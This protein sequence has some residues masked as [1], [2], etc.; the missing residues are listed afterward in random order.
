MWITRQRLRGRRRNDGIFWKLVPFRFLLPRAATGA[1]TGVRSPLTIMLLPLILL[2]VMTP[3]R[4]SGQPTPTLV[5]DGTTAITV[6]WATE[7]PPAACLEYVANASVTAPS[8]T[9]TGSTQV[10]VSTSPEVVTGLTAST[11]YWFRLWAGVFFA[12]ECNG[13]EGT[14]VAAT[15]ETPTLAIFLSGFTAVAS[16]DTEVTLSWETDRHAIVEGDTFD[17][18]WIANT[19]AT[20]PAHDDAVWSAAEVGEKVPGLGSQSFSVTG[21]TASTTYW[22]RIGPDTAWSNGATATAT[23]T[24]TKNPPSGLSAS[25]SGATITIM[26]AAPSSGSPTGYNIRLKGQENLV[27]DTSSARY[28]HA[29]ALGTAYTFEVIAVYADGNSA[30]A[31][32]SITTE[33]GN[34]QMLAVT[35]ATSTSIQLSWQDPP[36]G[37]VRKEYLVFKE[38]DPGEYEDAG[39]VSGPTENTATVSNLEPNTEY[40]FMIMVEPGDGQNAASCDPDDSAPTPCP[41]VTGSTSS[42]VSPAPDQP[43]VIWEL[44]ERNRVDMDWN[45]PSPGTSPITHYAILR[46]ETNPPTIADSIGVVMAIANDALHTYSH[47]ENIERGKTFFFAVAAV[48]ATDKT[49]SNISPAMM[50]SSDGTPSAPRDLQYTIAT[51]SLRA[52]LSWTAPADNGSSA[53][54]RYIIYSVRDSVGSVTTGLTYTHTLVS[55][56]TYKFTVAAVNAEGTGLKSNLVTVVAKKIAQKRKPSAPRSLGYTIA[57]DSLSAALSWT[58]PASIGSSAISRYI[59][60][61]ASDSVGGTTGLKHTHTLVR[62]RTYTITVA[63]VNAAGA[64]P[65]SNSVTVVAKK[66]PSSKPSAPRSLAVR[67]SGTSNILTW[68]AP[69]DTGT[70]AITSYTVERSG[71]NSSWTVLGQSGSTTFIHTNVTP[72][73]Q[74]YYRVIAVNTAGTSPPSASASVTS[75]A[76]RPSA[77]R[78]LVASASGTDVDLS[79]SAPSNDGGAPI[80]GYRVEFAISGSWQVL[81][82]NTTSRSYRHT[83]QIPGTRLRYQ[84]Y[85]INRVGTSVGSNEAETVIDAT[86]P[87]APIGVSALSRDHRTIGIEWSDPVSSGGSAITGYQIEVST[88]GA[89]WRVLSSSIAPSTRSY[90]HVD[91]DPAST[92]HYRVFARN[93]VGLGPPSA[94]VQATTGADV[95][96]PPA[97][98]TAVASGPD[99][100][101]LTWRAPSYTGGVEILG[102]RVEYSTDG[103]SWRVLAERADT[104]FYLHADLQPATTYYYRVYA[105]NRA[106]ESRASSVVSAKT[107]ADVPGQPSSLVAATQSRS[108]ITIQWQPPTTDGGSPL[109]GY[110]IDVSTDAGASWQIVRANTGSLNTAFWHKELTPGTLY[111]YRVAAVNEVGAGQ[112]SEYAEARTHGPPDAPRSLV[113]E[114]VSSQQ[115]NLW[116]NEPDYNGG[117]QVTGYLL[118]ASADGGG[119]WAVIQRTTAA[120]TFSHTGLRSGTAYRYRVSAINSIGVGRA[121]DYVEALTHA[122]KPDPPGYLTARATSADR[123]DLRWQAPEHDGGSEITGYYVESSTDDGVTWTI[124]EDLVPSTAYVHN[125]LEPATIYRYK[126]FAINALGGSDGSNIAEAMT[127]AETPDRPL[128]LIA[129]AEGHDQVSLRWRRPDHDGGSE[130]TGYDIEVS[131]DL[132]S[133]WRSVISNTGSTKTSY[134][135]TGLTPATTYRY[136]V[137]AINDAGTGTYSE[138]ASV[139]TD[140]VVP[141]RPR[142]LTAT[143]VAYDQIDL[144]WTTP[145]YDGG[146]PITGYVIEVSG[147]QREWE[148]LAEIDPAVT[149]Q[150]IGVEPGIVWSYRILAVNE[151]GASLPSEIA[152]AVIDDVVQRSNRVSEAIM[153]WFSATATGSA[154][155]A[156]SDRVSAVADNDLSERRVNPM[157]GRDG[158]QGLVNGASISES[159]SGLSVWATADITGLS[160]DGTVEWDGQVM[161]MH[162][163]LDG[164]LRRDI[165]IGVMGSRSSGSFD[166]TDRTSDRDIEGEYDASVIGVSPY[167]AWIRDGMAVWASSGLGWGEIAITDSIAERTSLTTSTMIAVGGVKD[168]GSSAIGGFSVQADGW[169][170]AVEIVGN[171]P[172]DLSSGRDADHIN[173]LMITARRARMML[174]WTVYEQTASAGNTTEIILRGGA[175]SD[176][177]SV[178]TGIS[179]AEF[180]GEVQFGSPVFRVRSDGRMFIHSGYREWGL[181]GMVELRS[182]DEYGLSIQVS[183]SYGVTEDGVQ[184]LWEN[185]VRTT[186]PQ[187]TG[188]LGIVA[189]Y[190]PVGSPLTSFG[191]YDSMLDRYVIGT[192]ISHAINWI[193]EGGYS[194]KRLGLSIKGSKKF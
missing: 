191:R 120:T 41:K 98:L 147:D 112:P 114:A 65:K 138:Y 78:D 194:G 56:R 38:S 158:L 9:W 57:T 132:G 131:T 174:N 32:T 61:S 127:H 79:W 51:D 162:G 11:Q 86:V 64:G 146:A 10:A 36:G 157:G 44:S 155:R 172:D 83:D 104:E 106:G 49:I 80:T 76:Q 74:I 141:D 4:A 91:L 75:A 121:S 19:S 5:V 39:V 123:I 2:S 109:T 84:V 160:N 81:V 17:I 116:W 137:A 42:M 70:A 34:V 153:P 188:Q 170:S 20:A 66:T 40:T 167:V 59:I 12:G 37:S 60:Y 176:W 16:S 55:G 140:A 23:T 73:E 47:F 27:S 165:L 161:S 94:A 124:I 24:A 134:T 111:R 169:S 90:A 159:R 21:L 43:Q 3:D 182:R 148:R 18:E 142:N 186:E 22:F 48:N 63:A 173:A 166:F 181:R 163:G 89:I 149:Y 100:I 164:M 6:S 85:A 117:V 96:E 189:G 92:Y 15:T 151:A 69:A 113:A 139:R 110:R 1:E 144:D 115:I 190:T 122:D 14:A 97:G 72:G 58:A 150:H 187:P 156:V 126:V 103:S 7:D 99:R 95:S 128:D 101:N 50:A 129:E 25:K 184:R 26:W 185:G 193:L 67:A 102:Y 8:G 45:P 35:G 177:N 108:E 13:I 33:P 31:E 30:P 68:T 105:I 192:R 130:I 28:V 168:I 119:S 107:T 178:E 133:S 29:G 171:L 145:S 180:G 71:D 152:S 135:V 46:S 77:P 118:E 54:S 52:T 62:G 87:S 88:D 82:Q 93:K 179:G 143:V 125:G 136:R 183:P 53:I 154:V 175:R